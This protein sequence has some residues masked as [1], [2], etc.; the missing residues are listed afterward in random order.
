MRKQY[1]SRKVGSD[2]LI[3]DVHRLVELSKNLSII[4]FPVSDLAELDENWWYS[5]PSNVPTP[6]SIASHVEL[7]D[8]TELAHPIILCSDGRLMDGMHRAVK[9]IVE[10][11][12]Y[13][14]AVKFD[15]TPAPDY[16]NVSLDDL[17]YD[18]DHRE[19]ERLP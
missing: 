2:V 7:I 17:P 5:D 14:K 4:D 8:Q 3:W 19:D 16:M 12:K 15:E 10:G 1:H 6:R 13:I 11:Q 9:A 18:E